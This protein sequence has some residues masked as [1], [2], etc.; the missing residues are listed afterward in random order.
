E[1]H[2]NR[3][4]DA[5]EA[6][7][8]VEGPHQPE[9]QQRIANLTAKKLEIVTERKFRTNEKPRIKLTTRNLETVTVKLYRID[10]TDYFRKMHL[11][12]GV[13]S[14]DI[15]LIDPDKSWEQKIEGYE[16]YRRFDQQIEIPMEG[17]G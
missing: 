5:L 1:M 16:K 9:A 14:L 6:Y 12:T 8:K 7:K 10:L 3:L 2:L 13:E 4:A 15:A 11:A 17:A